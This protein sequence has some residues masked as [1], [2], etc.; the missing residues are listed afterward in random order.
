MNKPEEEDDT[1]ISKKKKVLLSKSALYAPL[2]AY[3]QSELEPSE[4]ANNQISSK[5]PK[6]IMEST[7]TS[8]LRSVSYTYHRKRARSYDPKNNGSRPQSLLDVDYQD[9]LF[10]SAT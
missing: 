7:L 4:Y 9:D 3:Q 1:T 6:S 10:E 8:F 5:I 2:A